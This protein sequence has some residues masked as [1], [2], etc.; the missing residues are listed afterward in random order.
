MSN[1]GASRL[2]RILVNVANEAVGRGRLEH[3][4]LGRIEADRSLRPDHL[5][6]AIP[7]TA[8]LVSRRVYPQLTPGDRVLIG[9]VNRGSDPIVIDVV[10]TSHA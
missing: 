9:W 8:Y 10:V 4:E 6:V 2:A 7:P 3:L 1:V 5:S